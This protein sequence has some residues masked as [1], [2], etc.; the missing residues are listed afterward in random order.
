MG[1]SEAAGLAAGYCPPEFVGWSWDLYDSL[2]TVP[3]RSSYSK[4]RIPAERKGGQRI[5]DAGEYGAKIIVEF[6]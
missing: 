3:T 1:A 2:H 5:G 4:S 6:L